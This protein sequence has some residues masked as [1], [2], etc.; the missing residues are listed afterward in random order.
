MTASE[1]DSMETPKIKRIK[2]GLSVVLMT[3]PPALLRGLPRA[4]K[5][6]ISEIVRK[7]IR[8]VKYDSDG[9]AELQF[10]DS[11]GVIH[12][13]YVNPKFIKAAKSNRRA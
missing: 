10:T 9:R 13:V 6:A 7:P 4:D 8:L 1:A 2:P 12:F 5:K 11:F 3:M